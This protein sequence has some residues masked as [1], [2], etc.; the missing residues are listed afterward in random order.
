MYQLYAKNPKQ[1]ITMLDNDLILK[2]VKDIYAKQMF[3]NKM[4]QIRKWKDKKKNCESCTLPFCDDDEK[5]NTQNK[6]NNKLKKKHPKLKKKK[7]KKKEKKYPNSIQ[8]FFFSIFF[9]CFLKK[10]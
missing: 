1:N 6:I 10:L 3:D 7:K 8:L 4:C 9:G 5:N 2:L